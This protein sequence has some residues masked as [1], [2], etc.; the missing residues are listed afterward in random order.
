MTTI[1]AVVARGWHAFRRVLRALRQLATDK[2]IP[3]WVRVLLLVGCVQIPV[4]PIDEIALVLALTII[5]VWY[6]PPL[7]DALRTARGRQS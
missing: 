2:R 4:L 3:R 1:G 5:A 6:R 7:R